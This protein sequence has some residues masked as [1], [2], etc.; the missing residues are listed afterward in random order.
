M[1]LPPLITP[2]TVSPVNDVPTAT[3]KVLVAPPN[4]TG[5]AIEKFF[6]AWTNNPVSVVPFKKT[7]K[8]VLRWAKH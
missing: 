8:A 4:E 5:H 2:L 1:P 6:L 7:A 3:V